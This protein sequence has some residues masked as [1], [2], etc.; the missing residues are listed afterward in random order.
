MLS[1]FVVLILSQA[2]SHCT[3]TFK[4][5]NTLFFM[6]EQG[7]DNSAYISLMQ[8]SCLQVPYF[9]IPFEPSHTRFFTGI[10]L[11]QRYSGSL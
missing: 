3:D 5:K 7:I 4:A 8:S 10:H 6:S 2:L 11:V 9:I 1:Y